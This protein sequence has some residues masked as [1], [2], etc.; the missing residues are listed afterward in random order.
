[1]LLYLWKTIHEAEFGTD[2]A[3]EITDS[4]KFD[5][6][7]IG[8]GGAITTD[9][10]NPAR[11]LRSK[12]ETH[13]TEVTKYNAIADGEDGSDVL[14]NTIDFQNHLRNVW[15]GA[16]T[17]RMSNYL[18]EILSCNLD[19]IDFRYYVSTMMDAVLQVV[20]KEFSLPENYPTGH[21]NE[22]KHWLKLNHTGYFLVPVA[23]T[24]GSRQ[25]LAVEGA[26]AVYWNHK[27]YVEFLD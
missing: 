7:K 8:K 17:K 9:T 19:A 4:S 10:C 14:M 25:D 6:S 18:N 22:F 12:L 23:R 16:I 21:G 13:V 27:Y 5:I 24:S 20:E 26:A 11:L 1:M 3:H 15:I 2:A